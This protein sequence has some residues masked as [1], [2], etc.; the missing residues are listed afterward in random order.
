MTTQSGMLPDRVSAH[1]TRPMMY[2]SER[3][4][5]VRRYLNSAHIQ[6]QPGVV[7][8]SKLVPFEIQQSLRSRDEPVCIIRL[9]VGLRRFQYQILIFT[10]F[11]DNFVMSLKPQ[12]VKADQTACKSEPL[13]SRWVKLQ[14]MLQNTCTLSLMQ[15]GWSAKI[16]SKCSFSMY[17]HQNESPVWTDASS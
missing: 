8:S 5:G 10:T 7:A 12:S 6:T 15:K 13:T 16:R 9:P 2:T 4:Q 14:D 3:V 17:F 11:M 1:L